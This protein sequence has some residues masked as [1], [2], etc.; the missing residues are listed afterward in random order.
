MG[1]NKEKNLYRNVNQPH[2]DAKKLKVTT[3]A[4][5]KLKKKYNYMRSNREDRN[6]V[7]AILEKIVYKTLFRFLGTE[8]HMLEKL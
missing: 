3:F 7:I 8:K 4:I 2:N 5:A 1:S 6:I